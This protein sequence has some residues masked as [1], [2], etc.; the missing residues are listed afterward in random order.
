MAERVLVCED[1][2]HVRELLA[3]RLE[4]DGYDVVA[5][6][7]G[8]DCWERLEGA[9]ELPDGLVLD[10]M[11]PGLDGF[12]ILSRLRDHDDLEELP[13]VM[14]TGRGLERDVVR[15]FELGA[16]DYVTKPFSPSEVSARLGRLVR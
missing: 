2:E 14:V 11:L 8:E 16:D 6:D 10:L 7:D 9:D 15:G 4:T 5:I 12:G 13:V 1:D 3:Y